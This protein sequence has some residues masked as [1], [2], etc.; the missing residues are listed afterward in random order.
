MIGISYVLLLA[1]CLSFGLAAAGVSSRVG[2]VPLGLC[3][4]VLAS[5]VR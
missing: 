3:L 2:L 1:A 5:L 4:W